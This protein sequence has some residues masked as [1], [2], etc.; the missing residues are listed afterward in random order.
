MPGLLV[1]QQVAG[2]ANIQIVRGQSKPGAQRIQRLHHGQ[3]FLRRDRQPMVRRPGQIGVAA[4]LA[5]PDPAAQLIQLPQPEHVG[6]ID[7]QRIHRR[8]VQPALDDIGGQQ[9]I[10]FAVA[11]LGHHPFQFGRRQPPMRLDGARL[12]HDLPQPVGHALQ[13]L[14]PRHHAEHLPAAEPL[15]LQRL[16]DHHRI[17]RHDERAHR[18]PIDRRRRDDRHLPHAGQ[19]QL[20]ASEGSA[21]PSAS[22][23]ARRPSAPSAAP[24]APRQNAAPHRRPAAQGRKI[25]STSPAARGCR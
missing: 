4:L 19:R 9:N 25:R 11:E 21:S 12:R 23:H 20:Q 7:H 6:A 14:D 22:A 1:A 24:C 13:V 5:A 10:V 15:A 16:A 18:Q 2:A 3:S 8:H 17:E